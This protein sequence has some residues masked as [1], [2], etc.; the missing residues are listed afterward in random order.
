MIGKLGC[1]SNVK[2]RYLETLC[3][4]VPIETSNTAPRNESVWAPFAL[5]TGRCSDPLLHKWHWE[6]QKPLVLVS[7]HTWDCGTMGCISIICV[8]QVSKFPV[9]TVLKLTQCNHCHQGNSL[10][11]CPKLGNP[12]LRN[13]DTVY[14][15]THKVI[16]FKL[17]KNQTKSW[18][19]YM[20]L[21]PCLL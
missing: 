20:S 5:V 11:T 18:N 13:P 1:L 14:S 12:Q 8:E 6:T 3:H 16:K 21:G 7:W 10:D 17:F 4:D 19:V 15:G 9:R 2:G